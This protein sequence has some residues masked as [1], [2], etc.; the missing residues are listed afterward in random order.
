MFGRYDYS[1]DIHHSY[2]GSRI[3]AIVD[4]LRVGSD[5][6]RLALFLISILTAGVFLGALRPHDMFRNSPQT[7]QCQLQ[8]ELENF[9][10]KK[11][12]KKDIR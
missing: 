5:Q 8:S 7:S 3:D 9:V 12:K 2:E 10:Q 6:I 4:N 1:D 11:R